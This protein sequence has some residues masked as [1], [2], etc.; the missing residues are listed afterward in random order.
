MFDLSKQDIKYLPGVGPQR[1]TLLNEELQVYTYR[2]LLYTFPYKHIDR[3]RLYAVSELSI[4]MPYVQV[5]GRILSFETE[6]EG[7]KRR[8]VAHFTDGRGIID[9]IWF[10]GLKYILSAYKVQTEYIVFGRPSAFN[11]RINI[12]HPDVDAVD[13]LQLNVM[14]L[15]PYYSTTEKMKRKG[16]NSRSMEHFTASLLQKI[17]F[18][19]PETLPDYLVDQLHLMS[20][21]QALRFAHYPRNAEDLRRARYRLKFEELLYVQLGILRYSRE[22]T[23]KLRG[24]LWAGR[25]DFQEFL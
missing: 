12:V 19:I 22:R 1:A 15:Q 14:G 4:N 21:D 11:G 24:Y 2:D 6:G 13:S 23:R 20:A 8:L 17:D 7:R 9:L 16:L 25:R 18:T 10:N 5:K 3:S